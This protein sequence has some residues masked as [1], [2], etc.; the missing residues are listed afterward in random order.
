MASPR[1]DQNPTVPTLAGLYNTN[2]SLT[3]FKGESVFSVY[4]AQQGSNAKLS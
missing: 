3:Y 1:K 2:Y 4:T